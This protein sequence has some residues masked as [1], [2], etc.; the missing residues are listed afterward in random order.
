V[1][2]LYLPLPLVLCYVEVHVIFCVVLFVHVFLGA[3]ILGDNCTEDL[4]IDRS[5]HGE[6]NVRS[7]SVV[8]CAELLE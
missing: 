7:A 1:S 2:R 3:T 8:S 4:L 6:C 5:Q